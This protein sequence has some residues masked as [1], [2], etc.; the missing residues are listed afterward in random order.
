MGCSK[1]LIDSERLIKRIESKGYNAMHDAEV[2]EGEYAVVNTCGFIGD[3]KE[4]SI[5]VILQLAELKKKRQIGNL[6]VMGCL[7]ER[8]REELRDEIPEIDILYGKFDWNQFIGELP[9]LNGKQSQPKDWERKLTTSPWSAYVKV[10]EGCDRMCAYCA[11]PLITG[12]HKSR[13]MEEILEEVAELAKKGVKE[14]NIIAQDLSSYGLDLY[15]SRKLPEL[16]DKMAKIEGVE[17]IRMHYFYPFDFPMEILDVMNRNEN[18]CKYIDIAL[19]HISD[20]MLEG[21]NRKFTKQQTEELLNIIRKKVPDIH[22]RTTVMT[23]FPGEGEQEFEELVD[24]IK[25][26]KFERLG[27]FAYSEEEDTLAAKTMKDTIPQE[28]K[29]SRLSTIMELQEG[30]SK[31]LNDKKIGQKIKVLVERLEG[32]N[33]IGRTEFDSPEVD[34]EVI[35]ERGNCKPGDFINVEI[36]GADSFELYGRQI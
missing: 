27:G 4:E 11:I 20:K 17:W 29:E 2:V 16:I 1:N 33:A 5:Q 35:V 6:V 22:I 12:R 32:S 18:V 26:Y 13:S 30:I 14:F 19:Q 7:S 31:T 21:M 10:S 25:N 3:A 28:I 36:T 15:K 24:F 8:Y 9:D 23:G 34:Q